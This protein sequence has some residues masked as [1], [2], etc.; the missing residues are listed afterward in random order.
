MHRLLFVFAAAFLLAD[1]KKLQTCNF[2][3]AASYITPCKKADPNLNEC[4]K[5]NGLKAIPSI[6][7]GDKSYKYP[8]L[9]PLKLPLIEISSSN[10]LAITLKDVLLN[11]LETVVFDKAAIDLDNKHIEVVVS[12]SRLNIQCIYTID[13][14]ILVLPIKGNGP[15]NLTFD[16]DGY[17]FPETEGETYNRRVSRASRVSIS[18]QAN[19]CEDGP[20]TTTSQVWPVSDGSA[21][22]QIDSGSCAEIGSSIDVTVTYA[23]DFSLIQKDDGHSYIDPNIRPTVT[24]TLG[25]AYYHFDNL[26]GGD[27]NLGALVG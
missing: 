9:T 26:F 12:F 19:H 6:L 25:K 8:S 27:K 16:T 3:F 2:R 14:Q 20:P 17:L 18:R 7:K 13:G 11:G 5:Q 4:A 22:L 15:G 10:N 21:I 24:Y 23:F 1:A